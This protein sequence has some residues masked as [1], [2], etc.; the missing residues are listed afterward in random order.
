MPKRRCCVPKCAGSSS[1]KTVMHGFP[2]NDTIKKLWCKKV[3][4]KTTTKVA[5]NLLICGKHFEKDCYYRKGKKLKS[6]AV[7]TLFLSSSM[8]SSF[9]VTSVNSYTTP[10]SNNNISALHLISADLN[11]PTVHLTDWPH[12]WRFEY[13]QPFCTTGRDE[14]PVININN[15]SSFHYL[16]QTIQHNDDHFCN[17]KV[18]LLEEIQNLKYQLKQEKKKYSR[19]Y[20]KH[21][22]ALKDNMKLMQQKRN[23]NQSKAQS[24]IPKIESDAEDLNP[25]AVFILDQIYNYVLKKPKW[26][27]TTI[28]HCIAWRYASPKGYEFARRS[29]IVKAPSKITLKRYMGS[30]QGGKGISN[31]IESRLTVEAENLNDF[32][33]VC[34]LVV[35]D[36]A[37][38]EK[39]E[40]SRSEDTFYGMSTVNSAPLGKRPVLANKLLCFVAHGLSYKYTIPVGYFFHKKLSTERF[41]EITLNILQ[42]VHTCGFTILRLV[43]D[44]HK[45]NV[46]LF[47]T[48]GD[49][50]LKIRIPHPVNP[51]LPLFLSFDYCHAVKNARNIFLD[52]DMASSTGIIKAEY[53]QKLYDIQKLCIIKPI[54]YLTRKHIYP[55][56]F[57][58]MNV[59]R[60]VQLF[61]PDVTTALKYLAKYNDSLTNFKEANAT[62][63]YLETIYKFFKLHD[64]SDRTQHF[65]QLD[66]NC[67]PYTE[68]TDERLIWLSET[69][70][71]YIQDIQET[72]RLMNMKGLTKETAHALIFTA[73]STSECVKYLLN[74][75]HFYYVLTRTFSSDA[76]E[77][78]FSNVRMQG[79]SHDATDA[80]TAHYAIQ[81]ILK[82]GI[83]RTASSANVPAND[84][85]STAG[86]NRKT[87]VYIAEEHLEIDIPDSVKQRIE[88]LR[89]ITNNVG[90]GI[91]SASVAMLAGYIVRTLEE[92]IDCICLA[93]FTCGNTCTP[94][95]GLVHLRDKGS[96]KYPSRSFISLVYNISN[97][98]M[99]I[100]P[101]L[102]SEGN[103]L[104]IIMTLLTDNL[105]SHFTC[106]DI[107][108]KQLIVDTILSKLIKPLLATYCRTRTDLNISTNLHAKPLSR[109]ILKL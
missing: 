11:S 21:Q 46:A 81:Q 12:P 29:N 22:N 34:S 20:T 68:I 28:R 45:S 84:V 67:T 90:F 101:Y 44:N 89:D 105:K 77:S 83:I 86:I 82:S 75:Q 30:I 37:I 73:Q 33:R 51:A 23:T 18:L 93:E 53:L 56:T 43:S 85:S 26:T 35:D 15:N 108:H 69:F 54:P 8:L 103:A 47:K 4:N 1:N 7:P 41:H 66:S 78:M 107:K 97:V 95:L 57:E 100:I 32:E 104:K 6:G 52:H 92:R 76:V 3:F 39:L 70:P 40:Y 31:L 71:Q 2:S 94:L 13:N 49:G 25:L 91:I 19:L 88:D 58:K 60:A 48:L 74:E 64:V 38:K 36:M 99:D 80:K 98:V 27:E 9:S 65:K 61:S 62:I 50:Q 63:Q 16:P 42:K 87:T 24:C 109:K 102:P 59:L 106:K 14:T 72:S 5:N 55:N 17:D 10:E 79:G 96:L